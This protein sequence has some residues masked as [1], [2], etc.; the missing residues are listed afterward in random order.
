MIWAFSF[1]LIKEHLVLLD[2]NLVSF[3]RLL[4]SLIIFLPFLKLKRLSPYLSIHLIVLGMIQFG[5]MYTLYIHAYQY[6]KAYQVALFTI[7]TPLYVT[8]IHDIFIK[9]FNPTFFV[10]ALLAIFGTGIIVYQDIHLR[11]FQFGFLL[12]QISNICFAFGQVYY[13]MLLTKHDTIKDRNIFALLYLGAV[14]LTGTMSGMVVEWSAISLNLTQVFVLLYL[15][16]VASGL[17]FF[18]WNYGAKL[19]NAGSLAVLNNLKV[20]LAVAVAMLFFGEKGDTTKLLIGGLL[21]VLALVLNEG[22]TK[23]ARQSVPL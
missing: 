2:P 1:G 16:I 17:C 20:P 14:L 18:L 11:D 6:L 7:F 21:I 15:G 12:M 22:V 23:R 5:L 9:K 8:L 19:T 4:L 13:K 3:I 10:C